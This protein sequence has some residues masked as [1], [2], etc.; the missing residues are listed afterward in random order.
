MFNFD[1]L[2]TFQ[3]CL[4]LFVIGFIIIILAFVLG[5]VSPGVP[6]LPIIGVNAAAIVFMTFA[7]GF[8]A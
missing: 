5:F 2:V 8:N 6:I 4:I 7:I 1:Y 3:L